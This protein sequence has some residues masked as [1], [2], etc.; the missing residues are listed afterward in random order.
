MRAF[1][2]RQNT[3]FLKIRA[4]VEAVA[5][6]G[7]DGISKVNETLKALLGMLVPEIAEDRDR[8]ERHM[9]AKVEKLKDMGPMEVRPMDEGGFRNRRQRRRTAKE[10]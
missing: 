4:I 2:H 3:E 9:R 7:T 8:R 1:R 10:E 5:Y 6:A